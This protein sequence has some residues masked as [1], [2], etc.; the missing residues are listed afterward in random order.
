MIQQGS[1]AVRN[2]LQSF[3]QMLEQLHMKNIDLDYLHNLRGV[4]LMVRQGVVRIAKTKLGIR[5][6]CHFMAPHER[7]DSRHIALERED[8][9]IQHQLGIR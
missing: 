6:P 7:T 2:R 9:Q 5:T 8:H 4:A 1:V 3:E